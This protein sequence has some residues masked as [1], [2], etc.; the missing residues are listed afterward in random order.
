M[1][2]DMLV[3]VIIPVYN[4]MEFL[5]K[6]ITSVESQTY[7]NYEIIIA[8]DGSNDET[9]EYIKTIHHKYICLNHTG[10]PGRVRNNGFLASRGDYIAFLDSD[11][12]WQPGKLEAQVRFFI[13]N[14]GILICHTREIWIKNGKTISQKKHRHKRSGYIFNDALVKCIIGP[15]TVMLKRKLFKDSGMFHPGLEIAE[16]YELWLRITAHNPVGYIDEPLVIK[17]GGHA[18]QLSGKYG[19]IEYFRIQAIK[20]ILEQNVLA[21]EQRMPALREMIRKCRIYALGCLKRG[22]AREAKEYGRLSKK[23]KKE[24]ENYPDLSNDL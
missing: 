14:P 12:Q 5:K 24:L 10:K 1:K 23:Y 11:D 7:R 15:S 8:D 17:Y 9:I 4:R 22:K 18:D 21:P 3:S 19:H 16:D 6:A 2:M 20:G 13:Q